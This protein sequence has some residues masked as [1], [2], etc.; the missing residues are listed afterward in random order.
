MGRLARPGQKRQFYAI[1][2]LRSWRRGWD[3]NPRSR[4]RRATV[5]AAS[6]LW[7]RVPLPKGPT[8]RDRDRFQAVYGKRRSAVSVFVPEP[9]LSFTPDQPIG[10]SANVSRCPCDGNKGTSTLDSNC[11]IPKLPPARLEYLVGLEARVLP[12]QRLRKGRGLTNFQ[13]VRS[14]CLIPQGGWR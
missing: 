3:S 13:T 1:L 9:F 10:M 12:E 11:P 8:L 14:V 7:W 6:S 5:R 4:A 2:I